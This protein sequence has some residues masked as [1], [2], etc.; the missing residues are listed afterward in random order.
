MLRVLNRFH[1]YVLLLSIV[2]VLSQW[3]FWQKGVFA[4][5]LN[6]TV[7]GISFFV[8]ILSRRKQPLNQQDIV[9]FLPLL[10]ILLSFS[11]YENPWLKQISIL[12]LPLLF[13]VVYSFRGIEK[14][15]Y[16]FWDGGFI[17]DLI[18]NALK[19]L[20]KLMKI[21]GATLFQATG[22]LGRSNKSI[23]KRV[24]T[25]ISLLIPISIVVIM[26]LSSVDANFEKTV[27]E[28]VNAI[29][30]T[31]NLSLI[32]KLLFIFF[33]FVL[34]TSMIQVW[35][36]NP[37]IE[38]S[39][40]TIKHFDN[41]VSF[42]VVAGILA[43]Y[44]LFL[45]IQAKYLVIKDLPTELE[46]VTQ[47]VKSG[48]WQLFFLSF[49]NSILFFILYKSTTKPVQILLRI[50]M[51]ASSLILLSGC[52]RMAM[53]VY[54]YGF[55]YEKFFAA[56]TALFAV[57][58]FVYLIYAS[59]TKRRENVFKFLML[60][61]LWCYSLAAIMPIEKI[62]FYS[63]VRLSQAADSRIDLGEL[64]DLSVDIADDV[65]QGLLNGSLDK[66]IWQ[67]L[68]SGGY[69]YVEVERKASWAKWLAKVND[70]ECS[71]KWYETNLSRML[72]CSND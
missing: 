61:F 5:G 28:L 30:Q 42:V 71:S 12:V 69:G 35:E 17:V 63:N 19:P 72:Y 33:A 48:F 23:F 51:L 20:S 21:A 37:K 13:G 64:S 39:S 44:L 15:D 38:V 41:V 10:L 57:L 60:S 43:I 62:I 50:F 67:Q 52:W 14:C 68:S 4:F 49:M 1:A 46:R 11:V 53:Y 54:F 56:Y 2:F 65:R 22:L 45:V 70:R 9:W 8:L 34:F 6:S 47:I 40:N 24:F 29:V 55:S 36:I 32:L 18:G 66:G 59:F 7:V 25:G 31:I 3:N 58:V 16:Q 27:D 26:L